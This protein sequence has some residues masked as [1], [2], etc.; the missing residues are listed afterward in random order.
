MLLLTLEYDEKLKQGPPFSVTE[1]EARR[2]YAH[3]F[4]IEL[5]EVND[6]AQAQRSP[7]SQALSYF[8]ERAFLL[9]K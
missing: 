8:R 3:Q 2:L 9:S 4:D 6:I 1:A 7:N 5:L